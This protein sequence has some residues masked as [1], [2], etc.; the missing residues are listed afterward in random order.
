VAIGGIDSHNIEMVRNTGTAAIG[1]I[2]SILATDDF[3]RATHEL[4]AYSR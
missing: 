2:R 4:L 1:I 3:T